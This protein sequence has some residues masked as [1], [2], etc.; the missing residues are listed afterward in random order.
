VL[1]LIYPL[2]FVAVQRAEFRENRSHALRDPNVRKAQEMQRTGQEF[3]EGEVWRGTRNLLDQRIDE[4]DLLVEK[5][6]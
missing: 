4:P 6:S 2:I 5:L 1:Y 3:L